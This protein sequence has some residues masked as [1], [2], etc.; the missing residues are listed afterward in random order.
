MTYL[1]WLHQLM[2]VHRTLNG[3][4]WLNGDTQLL[5]KILKAGVFVS[6]LNY[7]HLY[8]VLWEI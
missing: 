4:A 7:N 5:W 3:E 6:D 8:D 1:V 2:Y